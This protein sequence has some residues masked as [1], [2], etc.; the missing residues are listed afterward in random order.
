MPPAANLNEVFQATD[1]QPLA[2]GDPHFVD[3]SKARD[4]A[5]TIRLRQAIELGSFSG[6]LLETARK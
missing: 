6:P 1:P 2:S 5:A 3:L 4:S